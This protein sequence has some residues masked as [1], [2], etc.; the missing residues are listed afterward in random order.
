MSFGVLRHLIGLL[1]VESEELN[2][3]EVPKLAS[4]VL[5]WFAGFIFIE[6]KSY[7]VQAD[8][9]TAMDLKMTLNSWPYCLHLLNIRV[10]VYY[11][12]L[13]FMWC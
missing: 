2:S 7:V 5:C 3:K 6:T 1:K 9:E 10:L 4:F 13:G 12:T 11:T 8:S